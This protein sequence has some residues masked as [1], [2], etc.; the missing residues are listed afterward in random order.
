MQKIKQDPRYQSEVLLFFNI[1]CKFYVLFLIN[2][3]IS[4]YADTQISINKVKIAILSI[5]FKL[6][7]LI[8][9]KPCGILLLISE[10]GEY[11]RKIFE[12]KKSDVI[13][14]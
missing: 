13:G 7:S 3:L 5:E 4:L 12:N 1:Y 11:C 8:L 6:L 2:L 10:W 14:Y 9:D